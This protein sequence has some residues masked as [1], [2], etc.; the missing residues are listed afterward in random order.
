MKILEI[1]PDLR[2]RAGAEVFFNSLCNELSLRPE[3]E[4]VVV[5]IWNLIDESFKTLTRNPRIKFY[6]CGKEKSGLGFKSAKKLKEIVLLEK[7]D[8]I[9]THRSVALSYFL[10]FGFK[11]HNWKY[12]H[13]V[14][15]I[16]QK[17]AGKY[18]ICLRKTFVK[19]GIVEHVG[20]SNE[21]SKSILK[22]YK[23]DPAATIYNGIELPTIA[24]AKKKYDFI[25]VARFSKQKNHLLLLRAF[26]KFVKKHNS[27]SLILVGEGELEDECK[28]YVAN[29]NITSNVIFYGSTDNVFDLMSES[30]CFVLS[31]LYEGNPISIL[32][33]MALG[34]PIIAPSIGGIPD[35]L[36][37]KEN[38]LLF[39]VSNEHQLLE[40]MEDLYTNKQLC[41]KISANNI[42]K[43]K[44]FS[45]K[46]CSQEYIELFSKQ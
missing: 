8:V 11:K 35:V 45:M 43:S 46:K 21:I 42:E 9:H 28:K 36:S 25:C 14:H 5:I 41:K 7:P 30:N 32:E 33:A 3:L 22:I 20:I 29:C 10:A 37:D 19:K 40:C 13:T 15:N 4:I 44:L 24:C 27:A 12:F 17:E 16:A 1:I 23:K 38:G 2:K 18:E 39:P 6:C 26:D 34:L 31:S